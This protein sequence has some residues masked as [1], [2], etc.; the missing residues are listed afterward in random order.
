MEEKSSKQEFHYDEKELIE[1]TLQSVKQSGEKFLEKSYFLTKA[2]EK[3]KES[4]VHSKA[5]EL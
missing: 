1:P 2:V 3:K 5:L 4:I